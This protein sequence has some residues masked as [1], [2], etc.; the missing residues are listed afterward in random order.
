MG[1][2]GD[3]MQDYLHREVCEK[4]YYID[5][6]TLVLPPAA[7]FKPKD[8]FALFS[9]PEFTSFLHTHCFHSYTS[10]FMNEHVQRYFNKWLKSVCEYMGECQVLSKNLTD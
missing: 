1:V 4:K 10:Y 5:I 6:I 2:S 7:R 3:R 8:V 9:L